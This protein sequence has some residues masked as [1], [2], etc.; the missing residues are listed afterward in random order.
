M[1]LKPLNL[2]NMD[3]NI[4]NPDSATHVGPNAHQT[5]IEE[6]QE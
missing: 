1:S 3:P 2:D 5:S 6:Q 4:L